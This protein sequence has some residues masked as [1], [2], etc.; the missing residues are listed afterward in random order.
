MHT[1]LVAAAS[2]LLG[3]TL[4]T[5]LTTR[6]WP[7]NRV[8]LLIASAIILF[9]TALLNARLANRARGEQRTTATT[10]PVRTERAAPRTAAE[11]RLSSV[12]DGPRETG[13]VKW[14]NRTKGFGFIVRADGSEIF[15]HQRSIR[16]IDEGDSRR[17]P[18]LIDGQQVAFIVT[19]RDK[20]PQAE[21]VVAA[22]MR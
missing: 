14:F 12:S 10:V 17:R 8:A 11:R 5:E 1:L 7:D 16:L 13:T 20:G 9:L 18:I 3:A 22:D 6:L 15:V 2:A 21:D 19:V 4:L